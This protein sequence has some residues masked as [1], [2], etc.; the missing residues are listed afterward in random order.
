MLPELPLPWGWGSLPVLAVVLVTLWWRPRQWWLWMLG[1]WATMI[2]MAAL[3]PA[4]GW[5]TVWALPT[6]GVLIA[7]A[8]VGAY[9]WL[10]MRVDDHTRRHLPW[11]AAIALIAGVIGARLWYVI[12]FWPLFSADPQRMLDVGYGG[13]VLYG[14]I[15][16]GALAAWL[17]AGRRQVERAAVADRAAAPAAL[18]LGIG[19]L[20]CVA[21]GCCYGR[22]AQWGLGFDA[23]PAW[24]VGSDG[25]LQTVAHAPYIA[26]HEQVVR[27]TCCGTAAADWTAARI[28]VPLIE[29]LVVVVLTVIGARLWGWSAGAQACTMVGAY[30]LWRLLAEALRGDPCRLTSWHL[31]AAQITSIAIITGCAGLLWHIR[32]KEATA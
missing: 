23:A 28:P 3:W 25:V 10:E 15:L 30:A 1:G 11:I 8:L 27:P 20:G 29:A 21:N 12:E 2:A 24:R 18:A 19:R 17:A 13:S 5:W 26:F 14:G 31:S 7:V 9:R 6:H 22:P 4:A 16:A 32:S